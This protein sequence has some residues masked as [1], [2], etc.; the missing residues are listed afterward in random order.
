V[1]E[2]HLIVVGNVNAKSLPYRAQRKSAQAIERSDKLRE[3]AHV[4]STAALGREER[5]IDRKT[6]KSDEEFDY[7]PSGGAD[8]LSQRQTHESARLG[9]KA[10]R[11]AITP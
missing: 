9:D 5:P 1:Q 4:N 11:R 7:A 6:W 10:A 3:Q 2:N 8:P